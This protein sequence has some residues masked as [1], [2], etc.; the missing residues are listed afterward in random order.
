MA[1]Y[2]EVP[3]D[4][5]DTRKKEM[6]MFTDGK[7]K[8]FTPITSDDQFKDELILDTAPKVDVD[9]LTLNSYI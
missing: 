7:G 4:F 1:K 2:I 8:Y 5:A 3:K 6:P 9:P